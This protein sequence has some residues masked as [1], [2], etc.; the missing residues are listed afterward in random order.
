MIDTRQRQLDEYRDCYLAH[1]EE[2]MICDD[3]ET[4]PDLCLVGYRLWE[5]WA[6]LRG[7]IISEE[8]EA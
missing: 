6:N 4:A 5:V 8:S 3:A 1:R 7:P 2:C